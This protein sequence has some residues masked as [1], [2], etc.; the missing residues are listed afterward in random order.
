MKS[1]L[2]SGNLNGKRVLLRVDWNV[3]IKDGQV[4]DDFRIKQSLET[5]EYI[6]KQ[7]AKLILISHLEP[8]EASLRPVFECAK[9]IIP[10]LT[11][12]DESDCTLLE[13]L[14][15]SPGE[16]ANDQGFAES[17]AS[18]ADIYVNEAFSVSH[19]EH[20]S[21]VSVPKM[22][23]SFAGIEFMKEIEG[24]KRFF[25]PEHPFLFILGGA[26]FETKLPLL[27]KF[28]TLADAVFVGGALAHN[29][30]KEQG[31][32]VGA[33][34]V[35][36]GDFHLKPMLDSGKIVL[37]EDMLVKSGDGIGVDFITDVGSTD[38][39]VD[40]GPKT[41]ETLKQK[42][43]DA[44]LILW[45]GPLGLY[46]RGFK[47]GTLELAKMLAESKKE[48]VIGGADTLSATKELNNQDTFTFVSAAG[49]AMLD[50]L[51][52]ETLPGIEALN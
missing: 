22:L 17:L 31:H 19:R 26:K 3:P 11:F 30:F 35:S 49:G 12:D 18:L 21:I 16:K 24:L 8:E 10:E 23:P 25:N 50:F 9:R 36:S 41:L 5:I 32:D 52:H 44:R 7:G 4:T 37:P 29:F 46:E 45:N 2:N 33:S 42:I 1:I 51:A 13:N 27:Q 15:K 14:R 40:A 28:I 34:L 20:A 43:N 6:R 47:T 38:V 39:I 48:T